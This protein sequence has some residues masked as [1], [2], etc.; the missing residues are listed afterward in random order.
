[1]GAPCSGTVQHVAVL[2]GDS[3]DTADQL[4]LIKPDVVAEAGEDGVA[5]ATPALAGMA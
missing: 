3:V 1:M 2:K 5:P 4:L